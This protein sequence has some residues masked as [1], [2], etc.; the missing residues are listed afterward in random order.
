MPD[1]GSIIVSSGSGECCGRFL[2]C[3]FY[4]TSIYFGIMWVEC[5]PAV[6]RHVTISDTSEFALK[7]KSVVIVT[8]DENQ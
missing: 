2:N 7:E 4:S 5:K 3:F 1:V 8:L 6:F